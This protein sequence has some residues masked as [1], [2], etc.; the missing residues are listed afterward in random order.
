[1]TMGS[2]I[3]KRLKKRLGRKQEKNAIILIVGDTGDGKSISSLGIAL[4]VD[5][6]FHAGR[7]AH[8]S[9]Q[10][11]MR[12]LNLPELKRGMAIV[13]D[14]VGKG[15]K[16]R[17]WYE[18]I[19]KIVLDVIQTFRIMGLL[20]ILNVPDKRLVDSNLLSLFH[21]WGETLRIDYDEK[22]NI[23]K[24]FEVQINRRSGKI[25]FKYPRTKKNGKVAV[26]KRLKIKIPPKE[27]VKQYKKD[28]KEAVKK[29]LGT[30]WKEILKIEAKVKRKLI[31]ET[32]I[33]ES[34]L[35]DT[36]NYMR[37]YH[38]R[39]FID[40]YLIMSNFKVGFYVANKVKRTVEKKI[41]LHT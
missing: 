11:F 41:G 34:I 25:Y 12:I 8:Q 28:K 33:V 36:E 4:A 15:L 2:V 31:T 16:R 10:N 5:S 26:I 1:M 17:D 40:H 35:Q 38:K 22:L 18:M 20:V 14:D 29:L 21:Y 23:L 7:V 30:S 39:T 9:A 3:V 32:E 37:T 24:F 19:N 13:W 27:L 6:T